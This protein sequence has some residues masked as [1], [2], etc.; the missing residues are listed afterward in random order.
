MVFGEKLTGIVKSTNRKGLLVFLLFFMVSI[1]QAQYNSRLGRFQ[2][3]QKK[4]CAP[5]KVTI[6]T[7]NLITTGECTPGKPCLMDFEGKVPPVQQQNVFTFTYNTPGTYK[8]SVLY[9]SIGADDIMI[10]VDQNIQPAFDLFTCAGSKVSLNITDTNYDQYVIDFNNDG[11]PDVPISGNKTATFTYGAPGANIIRVRGRDLNSADN[12]TAKVQN[13]NALAVIPATTLNA[14]TAIDATSLKLDFAAQQDIQYK[15]EIATNNSS[16]FQLLQNVYEI[17]TI[18]VPNLKTDDNYY[19][20]RL[21][22]YDPCNNTNTYS[23]NICSLNFD[24]TL[25]NGSNKLDW[26]TANTG[27][28]SVEVR[29]NKNSYTIIPGAPVTYTDVD[30]TCGTTYCYQIISN[31]AGGRKSTSLEKCGVAIKTTIPTAIENT[32][33]IVNAEGTVADLTWLQDPAFKVG[34]YNVFKTFSPG[35]YSQ[36][37]VTTTPKYTDALYVTEG[38]YCYRINYV[39][40]CKNK[41]AEGAPVC[42]IRLAGSLDSKNAVTLTW[43]SYVGWKAGVKNYS[44]EKYNVNGSLIKTFTTTDT[45]LVDDQADP[46]NQVVRYV[47]KANSNT[48]GLTAS[49]SNRA[50]FTKQA[51]LYAPTAFTPNGDGLNDTFSVSGQ[52]IVKIE[53]SIFDRWGALVYSSQKN[54]PWNGTKEGK[55]LTEG[56]YVWKVNITDLA[57]RSFSNS[58]TIGLLQ[59]GK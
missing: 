49:A 21:S 14:V 27:I 10:T 22:S 28:T 29:R 55:P 13:F 40:E 17:N 38:M 46:T 51:N 54:E 6:T 5:F 34:Q 3:D 58:G 26:L 24:L 16:T 50:D 32:S 20:F 56:A 7:T 11:T 43:S 9:Q 25:L 18:T 47:V 31:Y 23:N 33:S 1:A 19:C 15:M 45:T 57:G 39:D 2:V 4:G 44:V 42:P 30:I 37:A 53:L 41:S 48:V 35:A 36:V 8:L 12:C 52:F 59:K